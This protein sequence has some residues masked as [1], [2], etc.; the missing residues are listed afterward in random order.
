MF[1]LKMARQPIFQLLGILIVLI[2]TDIRPSAGIFGAILLLIWIA[3]A[4]SPIPDALI[5]L[6]NF[7]TT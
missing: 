6:Q 1:L 5:L 3:V 2:L 7:K 4:R